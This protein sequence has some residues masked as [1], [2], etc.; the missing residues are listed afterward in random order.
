M[1]GHQRVF[2]DQDRVLGLGAGD[3]GAGPGHVDGAEAGD[4]LAGF[5]PAGALCFREPGNPLP[6]RVNGGFGDV[7]VERR[8]ELRHCRRRRA[9]YCE[10]ARKSANRIAREQRI[11][12]HMDD[13][14]SRPRGLKARDPGN[15]AFEHQDRV[16]IVEIRGRVIAEMAGMVGGKRQMARPVLHD[17]D[18][19]TQ[20]EIAQRRNRRRIATGAGGDDQRIFRRGENS[21][22]LVDRRFVGTGR[23]GGDPAARHVVGEAGQRRRQHFTRQRQIDRAL[24][25]A[26]GDGES[27]VD[28]GFELLRRCAIRNPI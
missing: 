24:R 20:G 4:R 12:A 14:A 28:H 9:S 8:G 1:L 13:F 11:D 25:R 17:R 19:K 3:A 16:R 2:V 6:S 22:S 10:I 27:A 23:R 21:R 15:V 18:R 7:A 5:L 26:C